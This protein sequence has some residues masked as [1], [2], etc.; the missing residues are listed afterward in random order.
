MGGLLG[1]GVR[2][3]EQGARMRIERG[4]NG[5][6]NLDIVALN[7]IPLRWAERD[8]PDA[9][10]GAQATAEPLQFP[11]NPERPGGRLTVGAGALG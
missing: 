3:K 1:R 9:S 4:L 8:Y 2:S 10:G 11:H 7:L 6:Q 5:G